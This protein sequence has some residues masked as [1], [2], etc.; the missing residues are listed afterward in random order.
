MAK[1]NK[2]LGK[3]KYLSVTWQPRNSDFASIFPQCIANSISRLKPFNLTFPTTS[4][5]LDQ[6]LSTDP[7]VVETPVTA[8][9]SLAKNVFCF[10][11]SSNSVDVSF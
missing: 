2:Y 11:K 4:A 10:P 5:W 3:N 6:E 1:I 8:I 7:S 9:E